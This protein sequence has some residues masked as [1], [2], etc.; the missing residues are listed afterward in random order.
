MHILFTD[1]FTRAN[2]APLA[3]P[4]I[5]LSSGTFSLSSNTIIPGSLG[6]DTNAVYTG[7][8]FP[9]NQFAEAKV[10]VTGLGGGGSGGGVIVR[11]SLVAG[12]NTCYRFAIDHKVAGTNAEIGRF[13]AGAFTSLKL[14]DAGSWAD[15]DR[16][17]LSVITV[18]SNAELRAYRNGIQIG[19][20]V[21]DT[22]PLA[23]GAPGLAYSSVETAC[24]LDDFF[25]G[26]MEDAR[27]GRQ[28]METFLRRALI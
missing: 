19:G 28:S 25:A 10:L 16:F 23:S 26:D 6:S 24:T 5:A 14:F 8:T 7:R 27:I 11:G 3:S 18:G 22:S 12:T 15:G 2:E 21:T 13:N 20:E 9:N 17:A 4:W 1:N